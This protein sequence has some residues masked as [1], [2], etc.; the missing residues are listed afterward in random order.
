MLCFAVASQRLRCTVEFLACWMANNFL[1][2]DATRALL[3]NR[4][5]ALD[6]CPGIRPIG[7]GE[8]WRWLLAK[9]ILK[10]ARAE[11]KDACGIA[12]LCAGL[13]AGIESA[14]HTA[15]A[16]FAEKEDEEEW[17]FLLVDAA[18]AF[19]DGNRIACL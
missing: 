4:L 18:N 17:G 14:V 11:A 3:A 5:M 19:N 15:R 7:I 6:K 9:C 2:W 8:I 10:V 1:T 13:E 12:Q 16:L